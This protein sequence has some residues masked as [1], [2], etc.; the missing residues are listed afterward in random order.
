MTDDF[1]V[2]RPVFPC[3]CGHPETA[4]GQETETYH[5]NYY[6]WDDDHKEEIYIEDEYEEPV[7]FCFECEAPCYFVEMDNLEF[8]EWKSNGHNKRP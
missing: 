4:H 6:D 3:I 2:T 8:L 7:A 5:N 1:L